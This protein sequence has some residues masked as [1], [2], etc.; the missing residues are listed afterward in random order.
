M[1]KEVL[2][3]DSIGQLEIFISNQFHCFVLLSGDNIYLGDCLSSMS[4]A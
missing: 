3:Q 4:G 2:H 1:D